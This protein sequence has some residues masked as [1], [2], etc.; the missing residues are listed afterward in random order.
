MDKN[1]AKNIFY[2]LCTAAGIILVIS[3]ITRQFLINIIAFILI[4]I[5]DKIH[6]EHFRCPNCGKPLGSIKRSA[7]SF[8]DYDLT[9]MEAVVAKAQDVEK[10]G[11]ENE[12]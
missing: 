5:A 12:Q 10:T 7:C 1:T 6:K 9:N 3:I 2:A 8:C 4:V 11:G